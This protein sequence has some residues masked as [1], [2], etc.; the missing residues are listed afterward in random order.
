MRN[1]IRAK[2]PGLDTPHPPDPDAHPLQFRDLH[3]ADGEAAGACQEQFWQCTAST[4][5]RPASQ[6]PGHSERA[7]CSHADIAFGGQHK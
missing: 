6:I 1:T 7:G 3:T 5:A 4:R 2:A